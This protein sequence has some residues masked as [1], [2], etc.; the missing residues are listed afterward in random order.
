MMYFESLNMLDRMRGCTDEAIVKCQSDTLTRR[1]MG[2]DDIAIEGVGVTK[3]REER[4][5]LR[6]Q[7]VALTNVDQT[8]KAELVLL[9]VIAEKRTFFRILCA[10]HEAEHAIL[11]TLK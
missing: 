6:F 10:A 11:V 8:F 5:C 1:K 4:M 2:I 9:V 3:C 7:I